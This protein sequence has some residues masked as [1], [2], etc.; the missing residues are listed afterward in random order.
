MCSG[1]WQKKK[2]V[3]SKKKAGKKG[4]KEWDKIIVNVPKQLLKEF[5]NAK[6]SQF[7]SR[8][9]AI[10]EAMR[11]FIV[12]I[13][14][15]DYLSPIQQQQAKAGMANIMEGMGVGMARVANNPEVQKLNAEQQQQLFKQI[16]DSYNTNVIQPQLKSAKNKSG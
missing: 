15:E 13:M 12:N 16:P 7:Y 2:L 8:S 6:E 14:G 5:D 10:K 4:K 9:E 11:M 3:N 1:N